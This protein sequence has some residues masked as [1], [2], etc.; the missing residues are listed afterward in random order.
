MKK[1]LIAIDYDPAAQRVAEIGYALAKELKAEIT[2]VHV[3]SNPVYYSIS[4][5]EPMGFVGYND[6]ML[7]NNII[8]TLRDV[9]QE[10]LTKS[11]AHLGDNSIQTIVREGDFADSILEVA[12]ELGVNVIMLGTHGRRWY[13]K[14]VVGSVAEKVIRH[15][16]IPIFL[17][18]T[19]HKN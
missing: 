8:D 11:K 14:I 10:F 19:A 9:G 12:K 15:S 1:V 2:L 3:I 13:E 6:L 4:E 17:I 16:T 5:F 18:P 7:T